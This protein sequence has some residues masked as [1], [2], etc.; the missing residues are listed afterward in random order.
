MNSFLNQFK[1]SR[2]KYD[3]KKIF[4]EL[5]GMFSLILVFIMIL[6]IT[7]SF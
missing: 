1:N 4:C 3:A 7:W 6:F 5:F 2:G